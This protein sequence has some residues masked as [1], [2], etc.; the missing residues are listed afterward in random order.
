MTTI[1]R[2][3]STLLIDEHPLQVQPSLAVAV[4]LNE[5]IFMQQVQ[6]LAAQGGV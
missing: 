5:A 6:A 2:N 1:I 3:K 4:G